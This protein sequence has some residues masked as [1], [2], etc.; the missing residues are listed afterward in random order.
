[1]AIGAALGAGLLLSG[2][3][4]NP[5]VALA[6]G[7]G[8][9]PAVWAA[10]LGGIAFASLF[11][12]LSVPVEGPQEQSGTSDRQAAARRTYIPQARPVPASPLARTATP[13]TGRTADPTAGVRQRRATDL[14]RPGHPRSSPNG[15]ASL[16]GIWSSLCGL[17]TLPFALIGLA[18]RLRRTRR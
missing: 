13:A 2:G 16:H 18:L 3:V 17:L 14:P 11:D 4:L 8:A 5:A 15:G 6:M 12:L 7:L 10:A 9:S 1:M